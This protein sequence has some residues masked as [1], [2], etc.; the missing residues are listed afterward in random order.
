MTT[1]N[2]DTIISRQV[3]TMAAAPTTGLLSTFRYGA[4]D[5]FNSPSDGT[6]TTGGGDF[7][8]ILR[9]GRTDSDGEVLPVPFEPSALVVHEKTFQPEMTFHVQS[10]IQVGTYLE[11]T[12]EPGIAFNL[13]GAQT[14]FFY[15]D[16]V[17]QTVLEFD[18]WA[19]QRD[20][21]ITEVIRGSLLAQLEVTDTRFLVRVDTQYPWSTGERFTVGDRMYNVVSVSRSGLR[22]RYREIFARAFGG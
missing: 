22:G 21:S 15:G 14:F 7:Q 5:V 9:L 6:Y 17:V 2:F 19:E 4:R 11:F 10:V 3:V 13:S 18:T 20:L 12:I 16:V 1:P 8:G